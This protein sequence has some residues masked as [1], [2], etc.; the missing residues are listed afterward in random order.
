M[1][2]REITSE[3][4]PVWL[5]LWQGFLAY[6]DVT[7]EDAHNHAVWARLL[8]GG[9]PLRSL[10]AERD[11]RLVGFTHFFFHRNTWSNAGYC[12]LEDLYVDQTIRS[13]GVG[14]ALIAAVEETARN[15]GASK[16]YWHTHDDNKSARALYDK[17][18]ELTDFVQ[19]Q[20]V[21]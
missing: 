1:M 20:V 15:E 13:R 3:D 11:G 8:D 5:E 21:L 10:V 7:L 6:H 4:F 18:A 2:I 17:I 14:R 19:Y 9:D 12:Y 16:L